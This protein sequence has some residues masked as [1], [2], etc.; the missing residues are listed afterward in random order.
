MFGQG[1]RG[2]KRTQLETLLRQDH[3]DVYFDNERLNDQLN[4][5]IDDMQKELLRNDLLRGVE[6][7]KLRQ[8]IREFKALQT[9]NQEEKESAPRPHTSG[10]F[11]M[12]YLLNYLFLIEIPYLI[13][14]IYFLCVFVHFCGI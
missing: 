10:R 1:G 11:F 13:N 14:F 12:C 2:K 5:R 9:S 4:V 6:I 3:S 8:E 7:G